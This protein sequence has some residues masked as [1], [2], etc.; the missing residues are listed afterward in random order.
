MMKLKEKLVVL[1]I[2]L[3]NA[4]TLLLIRIP[5]ALP[6]AIF[7]IVWNGLLALFFRALGS[8]E[9]ARDFMNV[10]GRMFKTMWEGIKPQFSAKEIL[11]DYYDMDRYP[12][13]EE[14]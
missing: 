7:A 9:D 14:P 8:R 1:L 2:R 3:R 10:T 13:K 12:N 4:L 11:K 6:F 5:M